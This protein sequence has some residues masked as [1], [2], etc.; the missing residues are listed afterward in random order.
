MNLPRELEKI[1]TD[2]DII[3]AGIAASLAIGG[4]R[5]R[6]PTTFWQRT[7]T[8]AILTCPELVAA[9]MAWKKGTRS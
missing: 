4:L 5:C 9:L 8:K 1:L 7:T 3:D 6:K 2:P